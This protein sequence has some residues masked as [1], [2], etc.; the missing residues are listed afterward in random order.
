MS[1]QLFFVG[2][3][4]SLRVYLTVLYSYTSTIVAGEQLMVK[5][6]QLLTGIELSGCD[7]WDSLREHKDMA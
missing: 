5:Y 7:G 6:H 1:L 4:W 3:F 2:A